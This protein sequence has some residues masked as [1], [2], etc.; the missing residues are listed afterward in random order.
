MPIVRYSIIQYSIVCVCV[1]V[2]V[3]MLVTQ[4][5]PALCQP[6]NSSVHGI[7]Q[8]RIL[9]WVAIPFSNRIVQYDV[10]FIILQSVHLYLCVSISVCLSIIRSHFICSFGDK[11]NI[12]LNTVMN[13]MYQ[14]TGEMQIITIVHFQ[15]IIL[16]L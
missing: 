2:C 13:S 16:C 1:C 7:F 5:C 11:K 8:A 12:Y 14:Q 3:C 6:M 15:G 4:L 9:E 10:M